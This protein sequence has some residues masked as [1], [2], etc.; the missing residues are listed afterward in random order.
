LVEITL[1]NTSQPRGERIFFVPVRIFARLL[2]LFHSPSLP[3]TVGFSTHGFILIFFLFFSYV[4]LPQLFKSLTHALAR[5][6]PGNN[7]PYIFP[8]MHSFPAHGGGYVRQTVWQMN[9]LPL[10]SSRIP[11]SCALEFFHLFSCCDAIGATRPF[12]EDLARTPSPF[13]LKSPNGPVGM[14]CPPRPSLKGRCSTMCTQIR[15]VSHS[16]RG[17]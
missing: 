17:F 6:D 3:P 4:D 5:H 1:F 9:S 11:F 13:F 8:G 16:S 14:A 15:V 7:F 12:R 2:S 10:P